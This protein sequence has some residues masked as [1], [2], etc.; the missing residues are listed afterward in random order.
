MSVPGI[1]ESAGGDA[2]ERLKRKYA[3]LVER[4]VALS[5]AGLP[6]NDNPGPGR[7]QEPKNVPLSNS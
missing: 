4:E 3:A 2:V 1:E 5:N 7:R 6:A